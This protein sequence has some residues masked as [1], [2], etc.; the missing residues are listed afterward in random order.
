M[1]TSF[2]V[3]N[4]RTLVSTVAP[5]LYILTAHGLQQEHNDVAFPFRQESNFLYLTGINEPDWLLVIDGYSNQEYLIAPAVDPVHDVFDGS[6]SHDDARQQSGIL[7]ILPR[8]S[9][10]ELLR[11]L[12]VKHKVVYTLGHHPWRRHFNF[13]ANPT[14]VQLNRVLKRHFHTIEDVR[15]D[16]AKQRALKQ[17]QEID[18]V[19]HAI[20]V[21]EKAIDHA[22][23][24]IPN[25][26][27]EHEIEAEITYHFRKQGLTHAYQPIVASGKNACTLHYH[28]ET[29]RLQANQPILIDVGAQSCGYP[30]DIT[31]TFAYGQPSERQQEIY[32]QLYRAHQDIVA[33]LRPG[34]STKEYI[35]KVDERMKSAIA[36]LGLDQERYRDYF[37]HAISHGLGLDV[38][39]SL[40]GYERLQ[41]GMILTVEPGIYIPEEGIGMR[42]EDDLLITEEGSENLSRAIS[43]DFNR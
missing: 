8:S 17:P 32:T 26:L 11:K 42:I 38:H 16:L 2:F 6:L 1:D 5:K 34:L 33:L 39:E 22:R 30:A 40:G 12:T 35:E 23:R 37:P 29:A 28:A 19:R 10:S 14:Q 9:L 21:T 27:Y 36:M 31:R 13:S 25:S 24:I 18:Q 7:T 43:T 20:A 3:Q 15:P 41:P 4:R